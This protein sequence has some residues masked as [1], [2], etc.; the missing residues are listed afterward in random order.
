MVATFREGGLV[1]WA[2]ASGQRR[3]RARDQGAVSGTA[4]VV[5]GW[6][7]VNVSEG[8]AGGRSR[9]GLARMRARHAAR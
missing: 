2:E 6:Q 8:L 5:S 3:G 7:P 9:S 4:A 1:A